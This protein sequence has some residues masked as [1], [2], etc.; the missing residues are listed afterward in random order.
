MNLIGVN[1]VLEIYRRS[2]NE[3]VSEI[4][5]NLTVD[6]LREIVTARTN[7]DL[8][9]LPYELNSQQAESL[10]ALINASVDL[11]LSYFILEC[12][13]IYEK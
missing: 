2:D 9:Y 5:L 7:D 6:R 3:F 1:R 12:H 13:G 11:E 10:T 4:P 8:L